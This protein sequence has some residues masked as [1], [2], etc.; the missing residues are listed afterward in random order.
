MRERRVGLELVGIWKQLGTS[1]IA[2]V[3]FFRLSVFFFFHCSHCRENL[4]PFKYR[5][6]FPLAPEF[7]VLLFFF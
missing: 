4:L 1:K 6:S 7:S 3:P 5:P 2:W